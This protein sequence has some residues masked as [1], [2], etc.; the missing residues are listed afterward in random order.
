MYAESRPIDEQR[1]LY[2]LAKPYRK[3]LWEEAKEQGLKLVR[4]CDCHGI[5]CTADALTRVTIC[6]DCHTPAIHPEQELRPRCG[7]CRFSFGH[8][9]VCLKHQDQNYMDHDAD[10]YGDEPFII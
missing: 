9:R 4:N 6:V 1:L 7:L 8:S 10:K 5:Y 2:F 3:V